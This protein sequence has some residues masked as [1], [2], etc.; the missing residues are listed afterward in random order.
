MLVDIVTGASQGIG[1]AVAEFLALQRRA[2]ADNGASSCALVLTGR[3][4]ERGAQAVASIRSAL[5]C[6]S[7]SSNSAVNDIHVRFEPCD[8]SDFKD[9]VRLRDSLVSDFSSSS[10]QVGVLVNC[11]GECPRQQEWVTRPQRQDNGAIVDTKI[12]KQ[13]ATNVLGYHFMTKIFSKHFDAS[14]NSKVVNIASNWAGNLDLDDLHFRRRGYDNDTAYRQSKQCNRMLTVSWSEALEERGVVVNACHPG[15]PCTTLSKALGYNLWS[16]PP[17]RRM[18]ET[19]SP[20]PFLCGFGTTPIDGV[21]G[22]W[23]EGTSEQP[24][25]CQ[26]ASLKQEQQRLFAIC[27]SFAVEK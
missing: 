26:F 16:S 7:S 19:N 12:D 21:T 8:L 2:A 14:K 9:V 17:D 25:R 5:D 13:F 10:F 11:A 23:F 22:K 1:R 27:E 20:I 15:D 4:V 24:R 3:N 6:N 18:I